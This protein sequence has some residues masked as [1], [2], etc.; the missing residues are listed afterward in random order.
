MERQKIKPCKLCGK[1]PE[2]LETVLPE[3]TVYSVLCRNCKLKTQDT[4]SGLHFKGSTI[5]EYT[6]TQAKKM[7][8]E[9]WNQ[10][11]EEEWF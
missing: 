6:P 8:I 10:H 7:A 2:L 11:N 1:Q 5:A 4:A 3:R 9:A